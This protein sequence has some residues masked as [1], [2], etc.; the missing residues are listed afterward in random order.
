M[1]ARAYILLDIV[2]GKSEQAAQTLRN[3]PG[4][5]TADCLEGQPGVLVL[6][7]ATDRLKLAELLMPVMASVD[8]LTEDMQLLVTRN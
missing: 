7:E 3:M 1:R 4:V 6:V 5:A 2:N 8:S